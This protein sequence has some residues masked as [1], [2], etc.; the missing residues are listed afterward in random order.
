MDNGK[1]NVSK[2][3]LLF[4]ALLVVDFL[5]DYLREYLRDIFI[6]SNANSLI[7][8]VSLLLQ[9]GILLPVLLKITKTKLSELGLNVKNLKSGFLMSLKYFLWLI[10]LDLIFTFIQAYSSYK[11]FEP[12]YH[13]SILKIFSEGWSQFFSIMTYTVLW[14]EIIPRG[15]LFV[16]LLKLGFDRQFNIK[17]FKINQAIFFSALYFSLM[18][19]KNFFAIRSPG[20]IIYAFAYLF[21]ALIVG[22]MLG[23][24]RKK[25]G[26]LM[27]P[28]LLHSF[29]N[30]GEW[31]L[32]TMIPIILIN[33]IPK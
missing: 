2:F 30:F 20:E 15:L 16:F 22:Y 1:S 13:W 4:A 21:G 27:W 28:V 24:I 23:L 25:T 7:L 32:T 12:V 18:H 29:N 3:L 6:S 11:S 9:F 5:Q 17:F 31:T 19:L 26:S 10:V 8:P 14:Q 33:Q